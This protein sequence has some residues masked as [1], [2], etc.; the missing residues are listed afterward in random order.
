V[1]IFFRVIF[2]VIAESAYTLAA[3][4]AALLLKDKAAKVYGYS[5]VITQG[6]DS[7]NSFIT[8]IL[9]TYYNNVDIPLY[10]GALVCL[11]IFLSCLYLVYVIKKN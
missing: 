6:F 10:I 11:I 4:V 9:Y 2:N 8:P 7:L 5:Y 3:M 1:S